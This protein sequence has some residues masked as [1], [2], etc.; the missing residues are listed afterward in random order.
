[1]LILTIRTDSPEAEIGLFDNNKQLAYEIWLAHRELTGT[2]HKKI[3][4]VLSQVDIKLEDL[5]GLVVFEGP[6]S[7]TGLRIGHTVANTLANSLDIPI[8]SV[9]GKTWLQTG[10]K[11]LQSGQN[12]KITMPFYGRPANITKPKK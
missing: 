5:K 12:Q 3:K 10:I 6:G 2:I 7:F 11:K 1:M 4:T 9:R 8:I